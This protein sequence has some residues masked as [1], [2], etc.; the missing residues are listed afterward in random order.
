MSVERLNR[1]AESVARGLRT[2]ATI[3][4]ESSR[5]KLFVRWA[6]ALEEAARGLV[7]PDDVTPARGTW[8][9]DAFDAFDRPDAWMS[10]PAMRFV[11]RRLVEART[12]LRL[13]SS[14]VQ[15]AGE[16][17]TH[18]AIERWLERVDEGPPPP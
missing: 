14:A 3:D 8:L 5:A 12:L 11:L 2:L 15:F 16:L 1:V 17:D 9:G 10:E 4:P 18:G 6:R 13:A 7:S